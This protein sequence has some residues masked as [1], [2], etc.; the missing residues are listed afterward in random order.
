LYEAVALEP[1][2]KVVAVTAK[3]VARLTEA[4]SLANAAAA[5]DA[6]LVAEVDA[7]LAEEAALL[8]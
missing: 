6:A 4:V 2:D 5:D 8:A 1:A 7:A 3:L